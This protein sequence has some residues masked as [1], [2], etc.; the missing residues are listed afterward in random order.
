MSFDHLPPEERAEARRRRA[1]HIDRALAE[2]ADRRAEQRRAQGLC[3]CGRNIAAG[4]CRPE[5]CR[6]PFARDAMWGST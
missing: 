3:G 6:H 2:A 1:Q 4:D 5:N